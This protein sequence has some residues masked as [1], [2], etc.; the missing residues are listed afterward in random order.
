M[1]VFALTKENMAKLV[2]AVNELHR[3]EEKADSSGPKTKAGGRTM[4]LLRVVKPPPARGQTMILVLVSCDT[5]ETTRR[6]LYKD[7]ID[8]GPVINTL[9]IGPYL[10][11]N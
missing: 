8:I 11:V 6:D 4:T 9:A 1:M 7:F 2:V 10:K 3:V 5:D